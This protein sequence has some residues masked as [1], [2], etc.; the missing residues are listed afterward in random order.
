MTSSHTTT[1]FISKN[2]TDLYYLNWIDKY[3]GVPGLYS[4]TCNLTLETT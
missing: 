1:G 2:I 4:F 3:T